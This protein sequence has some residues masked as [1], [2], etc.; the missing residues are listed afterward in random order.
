MSMTEHDD[1]ARRLHEAVETA[2]PRDEDIG[3]IATRARRRRTVRWAATAGT[4]AAIVV[5]AAVTVLGLVRRYD[6]PNRIELADSPTATPSAS[7]SPAAS[8]VAAPE[9]QHLPPSPLD[10]RWGA[11]SA[12]TGD[13]L[14]IWGGYGWGSNE[15]PRS[16]GA[17]YDGARW[18]ELPESPLQARAKTSGVAT[19]TGDELWIAG[20][21]GGEDGRTPMRDAAAYN[22]QTRTWRELPPAPEAIDSGAWAGDQLVVVAGST[23]GPRAVR[24]LP[25]DGERWRGLGQLPPPSAVDNSDLHVLATD[26]HIVVAGLGDIFMRDRGS[27]GWQEVPAPGGADV[28]PNVRGAVAE[29]NAVVVLL[30]GGLHR[31]DLDSGTWSRIAGGLE[32]DPPQPIPLLRTGDG[33]LVAVD[34]VNG[35]LHVASDDAGWTALTALD[36]SRV[37]AAVEAVGDQIVVW[38][39][40]GSEQPD[41]TQGASLQAPQA[42]G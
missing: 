42:P 23:E 24:A 7:A 18:T 34:L 14:L 40:M 30:P 35:R 10:A 26:D 32:P 15:G 16:D 3:R 37:D 31:Y 36:E 38:G 12:S 25:A 29:A 22:P 11:F 6:R 21:S 9:W 28:L 33:G 19:W 20:G 39:G 13:Q 4:T 41:S 5:V 17:V 27:D 1:I 2:P 8:P